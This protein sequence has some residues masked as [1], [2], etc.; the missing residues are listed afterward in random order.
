MKQEKRYRHVPVSHN[1]VR[2]NFTANMLK[3]LQNAAR[4]LRFDN[5]S[6]DSA[7]CN[8]TT[9]ASS[10]SNY[11][12]IPVCGFGV[13]RYWRA[14]WSVLRPSA[15]PPQCVLNFN[16]TQ[17]NT[18]CHAICYCDLLCNELVSR[19]TQRNTNRNQHSE[20]QYVPG[21]ALVPVQ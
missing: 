12:Y 3:H 4:L 8:A 15:M 14:Q 13:R 19:S 16:D 7:Q 17:Y 10:C 21:S 5:E 6:E 2:T 1:L 20:C 18:M 11:R 9:C